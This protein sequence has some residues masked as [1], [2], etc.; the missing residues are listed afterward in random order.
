MSDSCGRALGGHFVS[1]VEN[2]RFS[3]TPLP[4]LPRSGRV[5]VYIMW[6]LKSPYFQ[7]NLHFILL[8]LPWLM[9]GNDLFNLIGPN[10]LPN[11]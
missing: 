2:L 1:L 3:F 4:P 5:F 6:T 7:Y 10:D 11:G 9:I 8:A